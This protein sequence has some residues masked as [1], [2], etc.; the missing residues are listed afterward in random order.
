MSKPKIQ[1]VQDQ[2]TIFFYYNEVNK[3]KLHKNNRI[4]L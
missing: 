2:N 3:C 4:R 1:Y